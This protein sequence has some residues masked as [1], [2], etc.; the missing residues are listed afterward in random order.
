MGWN[1]TFSNE[2][3]KS[4]IVAQSWRCDAFIKMWHNGLKFG[5][6]APGPPLGSR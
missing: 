1:A 3:R 2:R 6:N 4:R 5:E